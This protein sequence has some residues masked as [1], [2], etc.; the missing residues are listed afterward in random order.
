[1]SQNPFA[2][3]GI[4]VWR[5]GADGLTGPLSLQTL[6]AAHP[7]WA[8]DVSRLGPW[9]E[10][11]LGPQAGPAAGEWLVAG[12]DAAQR[13]NPVLCV[14]PCG[15]SLDV[16]WAFAAAGLLPPFASVLAL[17]QDKGRGQMRRDWISPPGNLYA[18]LA[19]PADA[20]GD[21]AVMAS[22]VVGACLADAL[23]ARGF[24]AKVKWPN[25]VL[26]EN[27]KVAGILLEERGGAVLAGIGINLAFAPDATLFRRDHAAAAGALRELGEIPGAD[28]VFSS[29]ALLGLAGR[30]SYAR[31]KRTNF[32]RGS[33]GWPKTGGFASGGSIRVR[34]RI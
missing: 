15:S 26:L 17:T 34:G 24:F 3:G 23:T 1:M 2:G 32:G 14:G 21:M 13:A 20:T 10:V 25:D 22:V 8:A 28:T 9:R 6:A 18:A 31:A 4:W 30:C 11:A 27:R 33:L 12:G 19:W 7:V 5:S 29:A 16:A